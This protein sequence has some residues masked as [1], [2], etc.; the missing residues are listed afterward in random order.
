MRS[1][2]CPRSRSRSSSGSP[3]VA[4]TDVHRLARELRGGLFGSSDLRWVD[5]ASDG[6]VTYLYDGNRYWNGVWIYVFWNSRIDA[7]AA[8][9]GPPPGAL[10]PNTVVYPRFDG[11]LFTTTGRAV[12]DP[13]VLASERLK[14]V[15][16]RVRSVTQPI[17]GSTLTLWKVDPPD[18]VLFLRTGFQANGDISGH[19]QV[20]VFDC[21]P[22]QLEI[23]ILG[24]DDRRSP[25][26]RPESRRRRSHRRRGWAC[27]WSCAHRRP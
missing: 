9:P 4:A 25:S 19:A 17:D 6:P 5:H 18:R 24:K 23:T 21:G 22:G 2:C 11:Q 13:Y 20:D 1:G 26:P 10:P 14:L 15:G 12:D 7:L 3:A 16:R 27:G 8:L